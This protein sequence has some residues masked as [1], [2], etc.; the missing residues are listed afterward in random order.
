MFIRGIGRTKFGVL[1]ESVPQMLY[2]AIKNAQQDAH[3][4]IE[5]ID[6]CIVSNFIGGQL[7]NRCHI[8]SLIPCLLPGFD[9]PCIRVESACA[10]GGA[11]LWSAT[12]MLGEF[13]HILVVGVE[14]MT[15]ARNSLVTSALA[16]ASD[17]EFEQNRGV[18]FPAAYALM[19]SEYF[20]RYGRSP[21]DLAKVALKNHHNANLNPLAHFYHKT[22]SMSDIESSPVVCSPLRL[23]DCSP[24]SDGAAALVV[25]REPQGARDVSILAC[26]MASDVIALSQRPDMA[27]SRVSRTAARRAFKR[28]G[29]ACSDVDLAQVHDCFTINELISLESLGFCEPGM[30][31]SL[32]TALG[33][34]LPVN[35]DGGLK[36]DGH[37]IG[38]SGIA[39]VVETAMQLR[40]E[41]GAR[42]VKGAKIGLA[43]NIGGSGGS[44]VVSIL[45]GCADV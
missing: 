14:K 38:A 28:A 13:N 29:I 20:A 18:V 9:K 16:S 39:Q 5:E 10:S 41:A 44:A 15:A 30:A 42:Q 40:G 19:A 43:H 36:A 33:G 21:A 11:A 27:V 37:P 12:K 23:L 34:A 22:I 45:K 35:T 25:S 24:V 1:E 3:I 6:A 32:D 26:E 4:R 2:S 7:E 8:N 17:V 31:P